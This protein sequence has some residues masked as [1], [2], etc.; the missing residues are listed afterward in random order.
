MNGKNKNKKTGYFC[1]VYFITSQNL[2]KYFLKNVIVRK[3][4]TVFKFTFYYRII[5]FTF[6]HFGR[7][8]DSFQ[9]PI[10]QF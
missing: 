4:S 7:R 5:I 6:F 8:K 3:F 9:R 10:T 2:H 1:I